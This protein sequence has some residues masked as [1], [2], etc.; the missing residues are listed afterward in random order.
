VG[1][2][3]VRMAWR[4]LTEV[5]ASSPRRPRWHS[6]GM[7][8]GTCG[9]AQVDLRRRNRRATANSRDLIDIMKGMIRTFLKPRMKDRSINPSALPGAREGTGRADR[10]E[11]RHQPDDNL[12]YQEFVIGM[13]MPE[14]GNRAAQGLS[15]N[16]SRRRIRQEA[17]YLSSDKKGGDTTA[18]L[19]Q[20]IPLQD[21]P[22]AFVPRQRRDRASETIRFA[23]MT[24]IHR[25]L[26]DG[27]GEIQVHSNDGRGLSLVRI[28]RM[29]GFWNE[30]QL[31]VLT[32]RLS[33]I[34]PQ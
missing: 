9:V 19:N 22:S 23:T 20:G 33:S 15:K 5:I 6:S 26:A 12:I 1:C 14:R 3:S 27:G 16:D 30:K 32:A 8:R 2:P 24:E 10:N 31:L 28:R 21:T 34:Y 25:V 18:D 13:D 4:K 17:G 11:P 29:S 7:R